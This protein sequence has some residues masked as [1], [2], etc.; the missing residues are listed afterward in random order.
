MD[1]LIFRTKALSQQLRGDIPRGFG[2][3]FLPA[4]WLRQ[5]F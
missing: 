3:S 1:K 5:H 2:L 4:A